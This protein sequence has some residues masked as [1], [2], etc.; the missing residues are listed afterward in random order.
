MKGTICPKWTHATTSRRLP[1]DMHL[2]PWQKTR[3][4]QLFAGA[5]V[6]ASGRR[7]ATALG[8]AFEA[9][10]TKDGTWH[11]FPIPWEEV[12]VDV[13]EAFK[14]S[15]AVTRRETR[16]YWIFEKGDISWALE[17]DE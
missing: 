12:P 2:H 3:A 17:S 1:A 8:V 11:G 4:H 6:D 9:K 7:F 15:G 10:D 5:L 14:T 16:R 13:L